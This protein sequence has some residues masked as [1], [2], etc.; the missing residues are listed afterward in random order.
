MTFVLIQSD[1]ELF[2]SHPAEQ[3]NETAVL[4]CIEAV[5]LLIFLA[6]VGL[7]AEHLGN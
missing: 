6:N 2:F 5:L 3:T 4:K 1:G 7:P